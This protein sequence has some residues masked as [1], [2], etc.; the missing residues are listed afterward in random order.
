MKLSTFIQTGGAREPEKSGDG[1]QRIIRFTPDA[2]IVSKAGQKEGDT[3]Y[4]VKNVYFAHSGEQIDLYCSESLLKE[5]IALNWDGATEATFSIQA[6]REEPKS[7]TDKGK[8]IGWRVRRVEDP[9]TLKP[10]VS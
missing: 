3:Y 6:L 2:E 8:W 7:N 5:L 9:R 4:V 1:R 10:E